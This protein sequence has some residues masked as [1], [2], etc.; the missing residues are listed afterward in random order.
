MLLFPLS[1][2]TPSDAKCLRFV[3]HE[4]PLDE[5]AREIEADLELDDLNVEPKAGRGLA[6]SLPIEPPCVSSGRGGR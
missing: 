5:G 3:N 1:V 4:A 6:W 2:P